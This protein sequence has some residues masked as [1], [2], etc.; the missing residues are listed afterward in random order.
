MHRTEELYE[1]LQKNDA[2]T[3]QLVRE[4]KIEFYETN[5]GG[6]TIPM[7]AAFNGNNDMLKV[8][9][10]SGLEINRKYHDGMTILMLAAMRGFSETVEYLLSQKADAS[11]TDDESVTAL[12]WAKSCEQDP[13][14]IKLLEEAKRM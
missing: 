8:F 9:V 3:I 4:R 14:T 2:A 5:S 12:Q 13:R 1:Q 11:L 7:R 10:E 6:Y